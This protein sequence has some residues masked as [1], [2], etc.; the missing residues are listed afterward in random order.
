RKGQAGF[1]AKEGKAGEILEM[2]GG[3]NPIGEFNRVTEAKR[4]P[5]SVIKPFVYL[6]GINSGSLNG[7]PFRADT[8][9]DPSKSSVAHR[10]T[11]GGPAP[12]RVQLARSDNGAAVAIAQDFGIERVQRFVAKVTGTDP[13]TTELLAIGAGKGM[14]LTP[15]QLAATYTMFPNNGAKVTPRA[16]RAVFDGENKVEIPEPKPVRVVDADAA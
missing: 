13:V 6:Y 11:T 9:I 7:R 12:A 1:N 5:G 8:V 16:I 14:E 10:Y 15:L 3:R 2:V 4:A